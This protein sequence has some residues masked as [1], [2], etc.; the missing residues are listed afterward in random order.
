MF[1]MSITLIAA[2]SDNNVIGINGK[3]PWDIPEY[4]RR[5]EDLT[6]G[7]PVIMG[8]KTYESLPKKSR[9]LPQRKNIVLSNSLCSRDRIYIAR[10]I[11]EA[12]SLTEGRRSYVIGGDRVY[13]MFLPIAERLE[14]F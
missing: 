4:M 12:L 5:F 6:L 13:E 1:K 7:H 8:R 3:I 9:P 2:V 11:D 14:R 10:N